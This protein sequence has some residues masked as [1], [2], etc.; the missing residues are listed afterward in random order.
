MMHRPERGL[1]AGR[2]ER[3]LV[4]VGLADDDRARLAQAA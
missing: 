3:E 2:A 4:Q 1:V